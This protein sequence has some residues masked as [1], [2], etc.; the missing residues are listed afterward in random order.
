MAIAAYSIYLL[1]SCGWRLSVFPL[2]LRGKQTFR[3]LPENDA[4]DPK[5]TSQVLARGLSRPIQEPKP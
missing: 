5:P 1:R 4:H 2:L 3:E